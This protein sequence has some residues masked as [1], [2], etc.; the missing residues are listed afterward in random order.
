MKTIGMIIC[1]LALAA[2]GTAYGADATLKCKQSKL[3]ALGKVK[4]CLEK[5]AA[6]VLGGKED[7]STDCQTKFT[8]ALA[9]A[10]Q[11]ATDAGTSCRYIDN[12]NDTVSDLNTGLVW[13]KKDSTCPGPHCSTT[14]YT[15]S[16][17]APYNPDG[18]A[19]TIFLYGLN[20]GTSSTGVSTTACFAGHCDWRLPLPEELVKIVDP[21]AIGCGSGS[22]CIDPTFGATATQNYWTATTHASGASNAWFVAFY[23]PTS[24]VFNDFKP[25][26]LSVR[27]VRGGL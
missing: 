7:K 25:N 22:P 14:Q 11:K 10:D 3:R 20:G 19:F 27:A 16:T 4:S 26:T 8:N 1:V 12:G 15:W 18:T 2:V 13:E 24:P 17:G 5:N 21:S 6:S 23:T 9:K